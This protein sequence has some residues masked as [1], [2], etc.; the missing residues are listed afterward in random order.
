M[1]SQDDILNSALDEFEG[2]DDSDDDAG[3]KAGGGR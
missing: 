1:A 3:D 2:F